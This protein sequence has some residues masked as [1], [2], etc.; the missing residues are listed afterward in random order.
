MRGFMCRGCK[1]LC[2]WDEGL[3]LCLGVMFDVDCFGRYHVCNGVQV[4]DLI[5]ISPI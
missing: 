3:C 1:G 4:Q 5:G 2:L